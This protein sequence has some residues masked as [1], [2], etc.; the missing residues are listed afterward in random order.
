MEHLPLLIKGT[1]ALAVFALVIGFWTLI[2]VVASA[3]TRAHSGEEEFDRTPVIGF[4]IVVLEFITAL[5]LLA[6]RSPSGAFE[7]SA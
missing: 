1:I 5:L 7:K 4:G 2:T 3:R 6:F